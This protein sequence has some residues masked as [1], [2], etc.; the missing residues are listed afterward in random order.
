MTAALLNKVLWKGTHTEMTTFDQQSGEATVTE[1][2]NVVNEFTGWVRFTHD[3][4]THETVW[5]SEPPD[6]VAVH[7]ASRTF[8]A[9]GEPDPDPGGLMAPTVTVPV[10]FIPAPERR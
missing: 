4:Q 10:E 1:V 5:F 7:L 3:G 2:P 6:R 8:L 9:P